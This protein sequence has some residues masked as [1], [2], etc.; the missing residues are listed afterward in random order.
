MTEIVMMDNGSLYELNISQCPTATEEELIGLEQ[1]FLSILSLI[2]AVII[3]VVI[4]IIIIISISTSRNARRPQRRNL[5]D[6]N[7]C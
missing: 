7:R 2:I 3:I 6:L 5:S 4:I 1:V